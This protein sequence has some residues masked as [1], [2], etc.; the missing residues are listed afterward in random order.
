LV[1]LL[2]MAMLVGDGAVER[3]VGF[4]LRV[5]D[6]YTVG[7]VDSILAGEADAPTARRIGDWA[8][9]LAERGGTEY[10]F[11][12]AGGGYAADG[13]LAPGTRHDCISLVYRTTELALAE[14]A[15]E[16]LELALARRFAGAPLDSVVDAQ[17][18]VDYDRPEHLDYSVDMVRSGLWGRDVTALLTGSRP[19]PTGSSRYPAGTVTTVPESRL[20]TDE[21][22]HGDL[23]WF[24]L[25]NT[26]ERAAALRRDHGLMVGHAGIIA[27]HDGEVW[28]VHA[29]SRPL[30]G[31][32]DH[33]G[34]V[35]VPLATYLA[36]VERYDAIIVTRFDRP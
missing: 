2:V 35:R 15:G 1:V 16:A 18:R 7:E 23:V 3:A 9:R 8:W 19:D 11:G 31:W 30:S 12:L 21:L 27:V 29:A 34:V 26:D 4:N 32:Y 20:Q 24:V 28:L 5:A 14:S 22:C 17:G 25:S 33:G 36:R 6:V 13:R 10:R